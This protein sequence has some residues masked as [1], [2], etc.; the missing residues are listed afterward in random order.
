MNTHTKMAFSLSLAAATCIAVVA[1][2]RQSGPAKPPKIVSK[3]KHLE[4]KGVILESEGASSASVVVE[5]FNNSDRAIV[6]LSVESG[7]EKDAAGVSTDGF[8]QEPPA[9][10]LQPY[11]TITM[12][13]PLDNLLPGK[14]FKVS[15]VMYS[16]GSVEGEKLATK[17]LEDFQKRAKKY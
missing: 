9:V 2:T 12:R 5:I 10:I 1:A 4:V 7:D 11:G 14:P 8:Y 3:V 13:M 6:A 15:G 16:D 17:R